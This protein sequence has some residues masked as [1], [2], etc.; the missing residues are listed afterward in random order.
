VTRPCAADERTGF[1]LDQPNGTRLKH[2]LALRQRGFV[3]LTSY[4]ACLPLLDNVLPSCQ[5]RQVVPDADP[6]GRIIWSHPGPSGI[7][8]RAVA[9]LAI[10]RVADSLGDV[11]LDPPMTL[12]GAVRW[13]FIGDTEAWLQRAR[14][15]IF[16]RAEER[17]CLY[18][19]GGPDAGT[20]LMHPVARPDLQRVAEILGDTSYALCHRVSSSAYPGRSW[21]ALAERPGYDPSELSHVA[22]GMV[23]RLAAWHAAG[24]RGR[25]AWDF[26]R[27]NVS[28]SKL[29]IWHAGGFTTDEASAWCAIGRPKNCR[30]LRGRGGQP[31]GVVP[32][33]PFPRSPQSSSRGMHWY[34]QFGMA[35]QGT[36]PT[37]LVCRFCGAR[38]VQ[39]PC[40]S[41]RRENRTTPV[42]R[43]WGAYAPFEK[44]HPAYAEGDPGPAA[45]CGDENCRTSLAPSAAASE[46]MQQ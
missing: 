40:R 43:E 18:E 23:G 35:R 26:T 7:D 1:R 39:T 9:A 41:C 32:L 24:V 12:P 15:R 13:L 29:A 2:E 25:A 22:L 38:D 46:G 44:V 3:P 20:C 19:A 45:E 31:H 14:H 17:A 10:V 34:G 6:H 42:G 16:V 37:L 5:I 36:P 11:P 4:D 8:P 30:S 33:P 21:A 27:H 28:P